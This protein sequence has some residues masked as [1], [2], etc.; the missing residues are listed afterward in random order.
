VNVCRTEVLLGGV[1]KDVVLL[2][3]TDGAP[4]IS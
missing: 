4:P 3:F 1:P 2:M